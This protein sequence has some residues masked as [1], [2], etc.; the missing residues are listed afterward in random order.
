MENGKTVLYK[1]EVFLVTIDGSPDTIE[2]SYTILF[3]GTAE[4][5]SCLAAKIRQSQLTA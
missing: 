1:S 3:R 4:Y 5:D 2:V